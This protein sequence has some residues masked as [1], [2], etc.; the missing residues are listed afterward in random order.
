MSRSLLMVVWNSTVGSSVSSGMCAPGADRRRPGRWSTSWTEDTAK[1][2]LGTTRAVTAAGIEGAYSG[3]RSMWTKFGLPLA[4]GV[5][6]ST[7]PTSTP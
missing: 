7:M 5:T 3:L 6:P 1:T 4:A 2:L